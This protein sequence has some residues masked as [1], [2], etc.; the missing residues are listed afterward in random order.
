MLT[1]D[2]AEIL[3]ISRR[4]VLAEGSWRQRNVRGWRSSWEDGE[5]LSPLGSEQPLRF[6]APEQQPH[7][8]PEERLSLCA[9]QGLPSQDS[10]CRRNNVCS[11][12]G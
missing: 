3:G 7:G 11:M 8:T 9:L 10:Q 1:E 2:Q 5:T 4:T 12:A 6:P